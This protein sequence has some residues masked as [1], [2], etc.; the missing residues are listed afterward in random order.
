MRLVSTSIKRAFI[1]LLL[2]YGG[3]AS[4]A[5]VVPDKPSPA[6][7]V[8]DFTHTLSQPERENLE[9]KLVAYDDSTST[10]ILVV[11]VATTGYEDIAMYATEI[12][13]K[14]GV[15]Q[16]KEDNGV[17]IVV[18]IDDRKTFIATG[19]GVEYL[20]T[21]FQSKRIVDRI[22]IPYFRTGKYYQGIDAAIDR[23]FYLFS[24]EFEAVDD[25]LH[26]SSPSS[27]FV[28]L[29]II[30]IVIFILSRFSRGGIRVINTLPHDPNPYVRRRRTSNWH[31]RGGGGFSGFGGGSFGGGGAGGS[32]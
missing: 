23:M 15:G 3:V 24:G 9:A 14:W 16:E 10:Q 28:I 29:I 2:C 27:A 6:K 11:I 22:M 13:Q 20:L 8:N 4:S 25:E 12:G 18:A 31:N 19:Y 17:V 1:L 21:D 30:L 26:E 32:W 7:L 5:I